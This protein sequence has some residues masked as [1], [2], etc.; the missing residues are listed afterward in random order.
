VCFIGKDKHIDEWCVI[1]VTEHPKD[2]IFEAVKNSKE[3]FQIFFIPESKICNTSVPL[4]TKKKFLNVTQC[5]AYLEVLFEAHVQRIRDN[6]FMRNIMALEEKHG[7]HVRKLMIAI[8]YCRTGQTSPFVMFK[9]RDIQNPSW[10]KFL[11]HMG[12][13]QRD[14][15]KQENKMDP[16]AV[17][18]EDQREETLAIPSSQGSGPVDDFPIRIWKSKAVIFHV[19]PQMD[20]EQHRRLV[21]NDNAVLIFVEEGDPF[22]P[23]DVS[24]LGNMPQVYMVVQP[25]GQKY[26]LACF[27]KKSLVVFLPSLQKGYLFE[28]EDLLDFILCKLHNGILT[29]FT[30]PPMNRLMQRPRAVAIAETIERHILSK[31]GKTNFFKMNK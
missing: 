24:Q 8:I 2:G 16:S 7:L 18:A 9:N 28:P 26:R 14:S 10:H 15:S 13:P 21:G 30:C 17:L 3:G 5:E 29:A 31:S 19:A 22:D 23:S 1:A 4:N 20:D 25:F 11:Q 12:I 6:A 27:Y